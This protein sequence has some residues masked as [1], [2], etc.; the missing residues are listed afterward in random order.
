LGKRE[1]DWK[2]NEPVRRGRVP[3]ENEKE[4]GRRMNLSE[5]P[6]WLRKK[7]RRLDGE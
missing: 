2:E 5:E 6:D 1:I 3:W 4:A 7:S